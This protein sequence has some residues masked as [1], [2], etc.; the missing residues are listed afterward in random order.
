MRTLNVC[1]LGS[2]EQLKYNFVDFES[3]KEKNEQRSLSEL[4]D[5]IEEHASDGGDEPAVYVGTYH[6]YNCGSLYGMWV[7]I[8]SFDDYDEFL[9]F[10]RALHSDEDDPELMYQDFQCF[11]EQWYC[12]CSMEEFNNIIE[13]YND[14]DKDAKEAYLNWHGSLDGFDE[15]FV[16]QFDSEDAFAW[17]IYVEFYENEIPEFAR[18]YFDHA[19]FTQEL[20]WDYYFD[21]GFVFRNC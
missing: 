3:R 5:Y 15:R 21:N 4:A 12:E 17:H 16:G 1:M 8:A 19:K 11:P 2:M 9:E 7:D 10:C 14:D 13:W 20:F 6:K 18:N